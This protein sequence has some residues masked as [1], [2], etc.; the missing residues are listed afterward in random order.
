M[1]VL[2]STSVT[3]NDSVRRHRPGG[4]CHA[5]RRGRILRL[6]ATVIGDHTLA[7]RADVLVRLV[8]PL[9]RGC[10]G[11]RGNC[12][13]DQPVFIL[14]DGRAGHQAQGCH[15]NAAN[16]QALLLSKKR[17]TNAQVVYLFS[18]IYSHLYVSVVTRPSSGCS[19]P[20]ILDRCTCCDVCICPRWFLKCHAILNHSVVC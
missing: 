13:G 20:T 18:L 11:F 7:H 14:R 2:G 16:K 5:V 1:C 10:R 4:H 3:W 8:Q 17:S 15:Q 12:K 19:I 6:C 9:Q